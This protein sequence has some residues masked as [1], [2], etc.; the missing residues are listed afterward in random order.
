MAAARA[1]R[2][3]I[4]DIR[5]VFRAHADSVKALP[6]QAYMKSAMPFLGLPA[7]ER[8][9]LQRPVFDR[10]VIESTGTLV[11]TTLGLWR[12][13]EFREERYA[14]I[15][16]PGVKAWQAFETLECLRPY[17]EMITTGAWWDTCD[18]LSGSRVP[19]LLRAYP[20][21]MAAALDRWAT[22]TDLWLR[23]AAILSQR[24]LGADADAGL[25]YRCIL[26]SIDS[27]AFFLRKAI[28]SALRERAQQSPDEVV[29]FCT[30]HRDR[31]NA[32]TK[33]EALRTLLEEGRL[34]A[35]P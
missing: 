16:L 8:R 10:H 32:L 19:A 33:R 11:A 34:R 27:D 26:P 24:R 29:A 22:G 35:I 18:D 13:A 23:R 20:A 2:A 6:M 4:D 15:D 3:L 30:E 12:G 14:A 25:L 7:I 28:G 21:E 31:L 1:N 9:A 17:E 5:T